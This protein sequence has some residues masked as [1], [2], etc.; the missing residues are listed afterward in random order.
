MICSTTTPADL[1][2]LVGA[3]RGGDV[4]DLVDAVLELF[5]LE[6][7]VVER[8]GQAEAV[9]DEVLLARAVAVPHAVELRDG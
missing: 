2:E 6:R 8:R 7:A 3:G 5:E 4:D 1:R 9:V